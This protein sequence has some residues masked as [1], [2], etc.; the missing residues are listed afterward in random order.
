MRTIS[1]VHSYMVSKCEAKFQQER[2]F[3]E[4]CS[5]WDKQGIVGI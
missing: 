4:A 2:S 1:T 5:F 3:C